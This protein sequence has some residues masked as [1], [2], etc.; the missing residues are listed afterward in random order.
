MLRINRRTVSVFNINSNGTPTVI[1]ESP[2][3]AGTGPGAVTTDP[4]GNFVYVANTTSNTLSGYNALESPLTALSASP[5][6]AGRLPSAIALSDWPP[7]FRA[8]LIGMWR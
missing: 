2:V 8:L 3:A 5:Y 6:A 7:G 1:S 4:S